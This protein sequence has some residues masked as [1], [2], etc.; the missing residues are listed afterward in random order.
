MYE[1]Q[2]ATGRTHNA[3]GFT[4]V[5][6]M[7]PAEL[8]ALFAETSVE[9]IVT[10]ACEGVVSMI[11]DKINELDGDAWEYWVDL[12]YRLGKDPDTH[13]LAEHMLF[14]GRKR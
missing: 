5:Y 9:H 3:V 12:N 8:A 4:D 2:I 7:R 14:V 6:F 1:E 11:R 13:G 10:V